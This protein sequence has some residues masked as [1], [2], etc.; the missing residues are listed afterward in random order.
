[1]ESKKTEIIKQLV[2]S[3]QHFFRTI[4][5]IVP[6]EWLNLDLTMT[7]LKTAMYLAT[8]GPSRVSTLA[9]FLGVSTATMTGI[10]DRLVQ[11]E[12]IVRY[13]DPADRRAVICDLSAKGKKVIGQMWE[14]GT[15]RMTQLLEKMNVGQLEH[16]QQGIADLLAAAE[17]LNHEEGGNHPAATKRI[18]E[19]K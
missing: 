5:P 4:R 8:E 13:A 18:T 14:I 9:S 11:H 1:M 7:Q 16:M 6:Q 17:E 12:F 3:H 10:T 19:T 15:A 2:D